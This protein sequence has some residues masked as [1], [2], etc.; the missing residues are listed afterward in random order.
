ME[1]VP[2]SFTSDGPETATLPPLASGENYFWIFCSFQNLFVHALVARIVP[3]FTAG[4]KNHDFA[5]GFSGAGIKMNR[6]TF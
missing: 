6:P 2:C 4:G 1:K 5:A 3:A